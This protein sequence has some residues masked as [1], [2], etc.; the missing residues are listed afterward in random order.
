MDGIIDEYLMDSVDYYYYYCD[1]RGNSIFGALVV[2][3]NTSSIS[4]VQVE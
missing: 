1:W 4:P 3:Y 2:D